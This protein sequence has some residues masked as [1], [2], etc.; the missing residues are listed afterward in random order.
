M[1]KFI[2]FVPKNTWICMGHGGS[3]VPN[4]NPPS[5]FFLSRFGFIHFWRWRFRLELRFVRMKPTLGGFTVQ[6]RGYGIGR[7]DTITHRTKEAFS[8][9]VLGWS[10][11]DASKEQ[12]NF[13]PVLLNNPIYCIWCF[14]GSH[15]RQGLEFTK[16]LL[17][18]CLDPRYNRSTYRYH[19]GRITII[20]QLN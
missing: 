18:Y 15:W 2:Q 13:T 6:L 7:G 19:F 1:S 17:L 20:H 4:R 12:W 9:R 14:P 16:N 5:V 11:I 3:Q 10:I 8:A